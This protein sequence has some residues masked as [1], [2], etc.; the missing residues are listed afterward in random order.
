MAD[1]IIRVCDACGKEMSRSNYS[2]PNRDWG[3]TVPTHRTVYV[4]SHYCDE[5]SE[6]YNEWKQSRTKKDG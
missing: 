3:L 4:A 2:D 1:F 5:C 6:S